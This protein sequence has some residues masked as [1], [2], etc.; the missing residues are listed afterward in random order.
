MD[1]YETTKAIRKG[2]AGAQYKDIKIIA[3]TAHAMKHEHE[4]CLEVGMNDV[5]TKPVEEKVVKDMLIKWSSM[6]T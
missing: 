2:E 1:G 3:L 6:N 5:L 4:K